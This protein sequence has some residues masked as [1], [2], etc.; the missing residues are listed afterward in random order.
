L[1]TKLKIDCDK[2]FYITHRKEHRGIGGIFFDDFIVNNSWEQT[3][4]FVEK[5]GI[6][7]LNAYKIIVTRRKDTE[8][9]E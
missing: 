9:N 6:A 7:T 8:Y 3:F 1:Y 4:K 2:Y 5:A